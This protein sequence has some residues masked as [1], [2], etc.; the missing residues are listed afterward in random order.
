MVSKLFKSTG[1]G[2]LIIISLLLIAIVISA[3]YIM[4]RSKGIPT[5]LRDENGEIIAGEIIL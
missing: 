2:M 1:Y 3:G 4:L 5:P